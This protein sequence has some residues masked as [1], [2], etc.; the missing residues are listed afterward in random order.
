VP[1]HHFPL[2]V[3]LLHG[4]FAVTTATLMVIA[5]ILRH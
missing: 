1:E 3:V 2:P 5:A 4:V